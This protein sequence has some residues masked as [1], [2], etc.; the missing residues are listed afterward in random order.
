MKGPIEASTPTVPKSH[1]RTWA[2][3]GLFGI[4]AI[5]RGIDRIADGHPLSGWLLLV[6]GT[7]MVVTLGRM[8]WR[9]RSARHPAQ[10]G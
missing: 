1:R 7:A 3:V 5:I 10:S 2:F 6:C 8:L 9:S 4:L